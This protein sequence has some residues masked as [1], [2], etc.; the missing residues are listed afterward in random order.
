MRSPRSTVLR[1]KFNPM[2][3]VGSVISFRSVTPQFFLKSASKWDLCFW[4]CLP[5]RTLFEIK[6]TIFPENFLVIPSG[7]P[8]YDLLA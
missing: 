1:A 8:V 2:S 6:L 4:G 7:T 3:D 5:L